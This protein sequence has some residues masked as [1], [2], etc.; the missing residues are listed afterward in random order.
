MPAIPR[1]GAFLSAPLASI[2]VMPHRMWVEPWSPEYGTSFDMD[3][4]DVGTTEPTGVLVGEV[5]WAPVPACPVP[6]PPVAFLDGVSRVDARVF[7][8]T[9]PG[10]IAAGL[11]G[12]VGVGAMLTDGPTTFGPTQVH[13]FVI[14]GAGQDVSLPFVSSVLSYAGR[15]APGTAPEIVRRELE[16]AREAKEAALAASLAA[17]GWVVIAD[18]RMRQPEPMSVVGYVKSHSGQYLQPDEEAVIPL[19]GAA[20]RT[21]LFYIPK[22]HT[23]S[24]YL[25]LADSAGGHPWAGVARCE[26]SASLPLATALSLADLTACHLPR[27]GSRE[28]WDTRSPQNL[29]PIATLERR[30]WHLLGDRQLVLRRIRAAV[31][32]ERVMAGA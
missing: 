11:C 27:F 18:G 12:S 15:S 23:Y 19:L 26:V 9:G 32:R 21:P 6:L 10:T 22:P 20:E 17:E 8:E 24:W 29:V 3:G 28:F 2:A 1:M 31:D 25:R 7:L 30:L 4:G 5:P 14:S 13:R 16:R